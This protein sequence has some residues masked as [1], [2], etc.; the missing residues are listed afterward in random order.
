MEFLQLKYFQKVAKLEHITKAAEELQIAQPSLSNTIARLENDIGVPL[1]DRQGRQIKLNRFGKI[2]LEQVNKSLMELEEGKR[3]VQ[4]LAGLSKGSITFSSSISKILPEII[5]GFLAKYPDVQ[6]RQLIEPISSMKKSLDN[7]E[8]DFCMSSLPFDDSEI[9]WQPLIT[10]EI[11]LIVPKNHKFAGRKS[12]R[13]C[14]LHSETFINLNAGYGYRKITDKFCK[15]AGFIQNVSFEV[16]EPY[17]IVRLVE[18]GVGVAF[19]PALDW[20]SPTDDI[21]DRIQI[22]EPTCQLTIGLAWSKNRYLSL[23]AL[24]FK[25]FI[26]DYFKKISSD[27]KSI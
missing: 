6:F 16:G 10:E 11:F 19:I 22:V 21:N 24:E 4:D 5:G 7:G 14:E 12:V 27:I 3:A 8:I 23:A 15:D 18:Q 1:F 20:L 25:K 17:A 13:L 2:F 26:T 9:E